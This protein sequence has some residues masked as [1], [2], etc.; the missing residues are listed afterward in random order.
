MCV[1][2]GLRLL[3]GGIYR[4]R[5]CCFCRL[6]VLV[7]GKRQNLGSILWPLLFGSSQID[8]GFRPQSRCL[9]IC[10]EPVSWRLVDLTKVLADGLHKSV[11]TRVRIGKAWELHT[12][13]PEDRS[14]IY[15]Y[16]CIDVL[17]FCLFI[18]LSFDLPCSSSTCLKTPVPHSRPGM[19]FWG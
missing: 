3:G 17:S 4:S 8:R 7:L 13:L 5:D 9:F 2:A 19:I 14:Y 16:A 1:V 6:G 11:L 15:I 10:L 18:Y 12:A